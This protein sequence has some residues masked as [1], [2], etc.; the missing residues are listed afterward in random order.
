MGGPARPDLKSENRAI[1]GPSTSKHGTVP[2]WCKVC[3]DSS[4]IVELRVVGSF[5]RA[6][7]FLIAYSN[8]ASLASANGNRTCL[9]RKVG[10][11]EMFVA[12]YRVTHSISA[13]GVCT[14]EEAKREECKR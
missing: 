13:M 6:N 1:R 7:N 14:C 5:G 4:Q 3:N 9:S 2:S 10:V 12:P 8:M 11:N